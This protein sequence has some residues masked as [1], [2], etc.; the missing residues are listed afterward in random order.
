MQGAG[1]GYPVCAVDLMGLNTYEW[2][3]LVDP[4]YRKIGLGETLY[5]VLRSSLEVRGSEGDLALAVESSNY[6]EAF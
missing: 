2:S 1:T 4:M 3:I 6:G 5:N